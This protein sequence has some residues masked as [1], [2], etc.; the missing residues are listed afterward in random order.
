MVVP[1]NFVESSK[2]GIGSGM[3]YLTHTSFGVDGGLALQE[4][5]QA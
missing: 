3:V 5:S 1:F 2:L 4:Y